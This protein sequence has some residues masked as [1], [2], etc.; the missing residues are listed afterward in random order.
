MLVSQRYKKIGTGHVI[1]LRQRLMGTVLFLTPSLAHSR[2]VHVFHE[3]GY[4]WKISANFLWETVQL[5]VPSMAINVDP[6]VEKRTYEK[7]YRTVLCTRGPLVQRSAEPVGRT[8]KSDLKAL[9][10]ERTVPNIH[11]F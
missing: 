6:H 7:Y 10:N 4:C 1:G 2:F 3:P 5:V 11:C 9:N 8:I